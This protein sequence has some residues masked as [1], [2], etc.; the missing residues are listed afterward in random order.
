MIGDNNANRL[1]QKVSEERFWNLFLSQQNPQKVVHFTFCL[2]YTE[3]L[4]WNPHLSYFFFGENVDE[5]VTFITCFLQF[6][7]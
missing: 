1:L 5:F 6:I 4:M 3:S 2:H 7:T